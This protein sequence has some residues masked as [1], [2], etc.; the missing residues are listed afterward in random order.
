MSLGAHATAAGAAG[1]TSAADLARSWRGQ[2]QQQQQQRPLTPQ[3][4]Q[5]QQGVLCPA[6]AA[7]VVTS[8]GSSLSYGYFAGSYIPSSLTA[9]QSAA[10]AGG[11]AGNSAFGQPAVLLPSPEGFLSAPF[12]E[13][14]LL[15]Q[16]QQAVRDPAAAAAAGAAAGEEAGSSSLQQQHLGSGDLMLFKD[17][18]QGFEGL[19][20]LLQCS[21]AG[22][23]QQQQQ[24][25]CRLLVA[26]R[27]PAEQVVQGEGAERFSCPSQ[28]RPLY[29]AA[30]VNRARSMNLVPSARCCGRPQS[31]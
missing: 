22:Q 2:Q 9:V 6:D 11:D 26:Q 29:P 19:Q 15:P 28:T 18:S 14:P 24:Q 31:M 4:Q 1:S 10:A 8:S 12:Y 21:L 23:G 5:Q 7:N 30:D 25:V 17:L 20:L 16:Q 27:T 13:L 3:Q